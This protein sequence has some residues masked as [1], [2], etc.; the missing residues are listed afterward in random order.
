MPMYK[1]WVL[2]PSTTKSKACSTNL[3]SLITAA[4]I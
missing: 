3:L 2:Q 1:Q 4:L